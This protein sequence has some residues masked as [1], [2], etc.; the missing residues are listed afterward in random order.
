M[1][2]SVPEPTTVLVVATRMPDGTAVMRYYN[3]PS[4]KVLQIIEA[5]AGPAFAE[6]LLSQED[7]G[8]IKT[9]PQGA[10]IVHDRG[11]Q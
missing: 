8:R 6:Q 5:C 2:E 9:L 3:A 1:T 7:V 4:A 10:I 11:E